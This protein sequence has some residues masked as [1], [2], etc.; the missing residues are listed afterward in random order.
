MPFAEETHIPLKKLPRE[1]HDKAPGML[2][3]RGRDRA[4]EHGTSSAQVA[5]IIFHK[6]GCHTCRQARWAQ[7]QSILRWKCYIS[8]QTCADLK[9][10]SML[11]LWPRPLC[12]L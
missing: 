3:G 2:L 11:Y 12:H 5:R 7:E 6:L 9:G 4:T 8:D 1:K 10:T